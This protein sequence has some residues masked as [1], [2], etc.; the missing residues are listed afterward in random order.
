MSYYKDHDFQNNYLGGSLSTRKKKKG[1]INSIKKHILEP[2]RC[3]ALIDDIE[4]IIQDKKYQDRL[5]DGLGKICILMDDLASL[6]RVGNNKSQSYI[7]NTFHTTKNS[8]DAWKGVL[9]QYIDFLKT[10]TPIIKT[11]HN[12]YLVSSWN[13]SVKTIEGI[14][15]ECNASSG[16]E[17]LLAKFG[18]QENFIKA[19]VENSYFFMKDDV[20]DRFNVIYVDLKKGKVLSARKSIDIKVQSNGLFYGIDENTQET[21]NVP[22]SIDPTGN[23]EVQ[24]LITTLT[25]YTVSSGKGS[26]FQ[27]FI[28]SH[29]WGKAFDP[30]NFTNLW[31]LVIVPAWGNFL[32]D[33]PDSQDELTLK[34][35][36]TF[37]AIAIKRYKMSKLS[38]NS[39]GKS[40]K[41]MCPNRKY[42][43]SGTY[44]IHTIENK[45]KN[46]NARPYG[47]I[48]QVKV[49][50]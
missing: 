7:E 18:S 26:I 22:I 15:V 29:I 21:L 32:L 25:G 38:W 14:I 30:R 41:D 44:S 12:R 8:I 39:I 6:A 45:T 1:Y 50:I 3:C 40:Y 43:V 37:K 16:M 48:K 9:K 23:R 24:N 19:V 11:K 2:I 46:G 31:N 13:N 27:N 49:T 10:L 47:A 17:S 28:I 5:F 20:Y 33:K 36:N 35:I 42:V 34:M 4:L